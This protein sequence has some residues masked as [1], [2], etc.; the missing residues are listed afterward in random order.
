MLLQALEP[1]LLHPPDLRGRGVG[2]DDRRGRGPRAGRRGGAGRLQRGD[3]RRGLLLGGGGASGGETG[4]DQD[5]E[6]QLV[7]AKAEA[8][9]KEVASIAAAER[10]RRTAAS[11]A[12]GARVRDEA[13]A[14]GARLVGLAEA[15]AEAA[16][17]AAYR[18]LPPAVLQALAL[19]ELA[20]QLPSVNEL[21]ITPD[22]L[23]KLVGRLGR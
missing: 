13:R 22:V 6:T 11:E 17:L 14:T 5:A 4:Q 21:T 12:E 3:L 18:D 9:R 20:G 10:A 8:D 16:R 7:A 15:E 2:A 19:K 1:R 23:T